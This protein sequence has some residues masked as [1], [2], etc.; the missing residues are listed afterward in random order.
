MKL[1]ELLFLLTILTFALGVLGRIEIS[2]GVAVLLSDILIPGLVLTW[3][4]VSLSVRRKIFLPPLSRPTLLFV[5]SALLSLLLS[6][7][8]FSRSEV[9]ASSLF[10][11][12]WVEYVFLYIIGFD[13]ITH[14]KDRKNLYSNLLIF[15]GFIVALAG[16]LQLQIIPDFS[17]LAQEGGW[18]PHQGR[19]LSTFFDPNFVGMFFILS[20]ILLVCKLFK[21]KDIL[22]KV[23]L[24]LVG[25]LIF[26]ALLLTSS[27]SSYLAFVS[28]FGFLG[29]IRIRKLLPV[30]LIML[31]ISYFAVPQ[32]S[33]R[34]TQLVEG[35][36]S[37]R[38]RILSWTNAFEVVRQNPVFGVGFN[39]YRFAQ[40]QYGLIDFAEA[41]KHSASGTDSSILLVLA[42]TGIVG[43]SIFAILFIRLFLLSW[44]RRKDVY[45]LAL[46]VSLI[47]L[48]VHSQFVNSLFFPQIMGWLWVLSALGLADYGKKSA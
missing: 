5:L 32:V 33:E 15:V 20:L 25:F 8:Q 7:K 24:S 6:L 3:L 38:A 4:A 21:T 36:L 43:L 23:V 42:T 41:E 26:V 37:S 30:L 39:T 45:S 29:V 17:Q 19:V 34:I 2:P 10:L 44:F 1:V 22:W 13:L 48:A 9:F 18:D 46:L 27:R 31:L 14:L 12:R 40:Q 28:S 47:A 11:I 16:F 35:D